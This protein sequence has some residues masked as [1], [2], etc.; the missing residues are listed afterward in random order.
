MRTI[1][2]DDEKKGREILQKLIS[3]YCPDLEIVALAA[4]A[5]EAYRMINQEKPDVI[6]LDIEMPNEDGFHL[7]QR[8]EEIKFQ[9]IFT[10]AYDNYAVKAIKHHALDYLLKPIDIDELKLAV[11]NLKKALTAKPAPDKYVDFLATKKHDYNGRIALP[12]KDGIVYLAIP[13]II[14]VESDGSYS[15][16]YATDGKKYMVSKN[17]G[18][19]EEVLPAKEFFRAHKSHLINMKKVKKYLRTDGNFVEMEDGSVVEISRRKKDEFFQ[20]MET[21]R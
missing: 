10:T 13:E 18:E 8:F 1:I 9:V 17:L 2:I 20:L 15:T 14:R 6:F 7:L 4:D 5:E 21:I 12:I 3:Q 11:E 19:Y 16:F